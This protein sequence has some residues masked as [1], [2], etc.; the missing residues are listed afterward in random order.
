MRTQRRSRDEWRRLVMKWKRE[1]CTAREFGQAHRV[2][3]RTLSWWS[4]KLGE[5]TSSGLDFVRMDVREEQPLP[6]AKVCPEVCIGDQV[7]V[8]V[9]STVSVQRIAQLVAALQELQ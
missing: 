5:T 7:R 9:P 2:N 4:W 3:P 1:G 6:V 8:T